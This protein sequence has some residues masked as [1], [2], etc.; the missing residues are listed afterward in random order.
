MGQRYPE[1]PAG[2]VVRFEYRDI[3]KV[4]DVN[5]LELVGVLGVDLAAD[6]WNEQMK[7]AVRPEVCR[8]GG[9]LA[10]YS[11]AGVN[12]LSGLRGANIEVFRQKKAGASSASA[13]Q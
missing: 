9:D 8:L 2:C 13:R 10:V 6:E 12:V 4:W 7:A 5:R 3:A 1:R 11:V